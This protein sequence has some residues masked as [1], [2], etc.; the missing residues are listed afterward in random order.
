MRA[1]TTRSDTMPR[2]RVL[3]VDDDLSIRVLVSILLESAGYEPA[4]V[5]TVERALARLDDQ[6]ADL[7][8]TDLQM[9]GAGG[10]EL[11]TC[12]RLGGSRLPAIAMTGSDDEE[13]I[14]AAR[15]AGAATVLR[16]PFSPERLRAAVEASLAGDP[17]ARPAA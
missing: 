9:S 15:R 4:A 17:A 6:G 16:K 1:R 13:L 8:L 3:V 14:A 5:G 12:L 11:L 2:H 10:V 7:V